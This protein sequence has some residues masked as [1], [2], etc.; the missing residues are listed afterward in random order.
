[1]RSIFSILNIESPSNETGQRP[2][3]GVVTWDD[4]AGRVRLLVLLT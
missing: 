4:G 1:M 3:T 2:T